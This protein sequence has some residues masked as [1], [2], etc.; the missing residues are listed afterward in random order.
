MTKTMFSNYVKKLCK[1]VEI[2]SIFT[3]E[4]AN[5][6]TLQTTLT[7]CYFHPKL[8]QSA[9]FTQN[10]VIFIPNCFSLHYSH[11][12]MLLTI[13]HNTQS[14]YELPQ[15]VFGCWTTAFT[16][17]HLWTSQTGRRMEKL[18]MSLLSAGR[19]GPAAAAA[20]K[21]LTSSLL[22]KLP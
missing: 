7:Q 15:N 13:T 5:C 11:R 18:V 20:A 3:V 9:L 17:Q 19:D 6:W 4:Q 1:A 10:N 2:I 21:L 8:H 12:T 14:S 22:C 16:R